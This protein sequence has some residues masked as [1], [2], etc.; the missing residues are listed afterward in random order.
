M[1]IGDPLSG[2]CCVMEIWNCVEIY[3]FDEARGIDTSMVRS[4]S[5]TDGLWRL[6][7]AHL[8]HWISQLFKLFN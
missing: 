4:A 1:A 8:K 7:I 6:I 2:M 3:T 5:D